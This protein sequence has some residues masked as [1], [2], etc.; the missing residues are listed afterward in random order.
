M[1]LGMKHL[2]VTSILLCV[3]LALLAPGC[4]QTTTP[5]TGYDPSLIKPLEV[6]PSAAIEIELSMPDFPG[7]DKPVKFFATIGIVEE[8]NGDAP[9]TT[10]EIILPKGFELVE[11]DLKKTADIMRGAPV[12]MQVTIKAIDV[13]IW[14][15]TAKATCPPGAEPCVGGVAK[16]LAYVR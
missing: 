14:Q 2:L 5:A 6:D 3:A 7:L 9:N 15:I 1:N 11:G 16:L 12:K 8:Y 4:G 10:I 13:G